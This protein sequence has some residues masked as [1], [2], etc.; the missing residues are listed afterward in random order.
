MR[1]L[2]FLSIISLFSFLFSGCLVRTYVVEKPRTDLEITGNQGYL[3]GSPSQTV[4]PKKRLSP[5][6]KITVIEIELGEH[7]PKLEGKKTQ[8][9]EVLG[10]VEEEENL[11]VEAKPEEVSTE[12]IILEEPQKNPVFKEEEIPSQPE[13]EYILYTVKKGDT[14]QKISHKFY[15]STKK[16]KKIYEVN[17]DILKGPDK[18]YPGQILKIPQD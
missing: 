17:K 16:W 15:K 13:K 3:Q 18:V 1:S 6:R 10:E 4:Q 2:I 8:Q 7:P 9:E 14:L 5:T 12:D 11:E